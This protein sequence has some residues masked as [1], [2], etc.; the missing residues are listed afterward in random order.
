MKEYKLGFIGCGHMGMA[1][2]GGV[3][4]RGFL[5]PSDI[6]VYD[7]SEKVIDTCR[8]TGIVPVSDEREVCRK[9]HVVLLATRPQDN[10]EVLKKI[11]GQDIDVLLSIVTGVSIKYLQDKLGDVAIIRAMPN[12]PLQVGKGSTVLCRSDDCPDEDYVFV[13]QLFETAGITRD[14][15]EDMINACVCVHG[16]IPAYVYYLSECILEDMKKRG[17]R[18]EDI[19]DLLIETVIG[20]GYLMKENS[21]RPLSELIDQVCSKGGTTIEAITEMRKRNMD[22]IIADA[23]TLCIN[24]ANELGK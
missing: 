20:S 6:C 22:K 5:R 1:I 13:K 9:A 24:R 2:A 7:P 15:P 17:F 21:D 11:S 18:E 8:E 14:M 3:L 19:K 12:T 10:D 16:S 23:D 4:S